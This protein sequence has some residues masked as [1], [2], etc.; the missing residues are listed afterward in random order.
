MNVIR[1]TAAHMLVMLP[2]VLA[3]NAAAQRAV[4]EGARIR[5]RL[6]G[7]EPIV[8]RLISVGGDSLLLSPARTNDFRTYP[9]SEIQ[10][11]KLSHAGI[12]GAAWKGMT[13]GSLG[14][15]AFLG[16]M[17]HEEALG[18]TLFGAFLGSG[19]GLVFGHAAS[20]ESGRLPPCRRSGRN[21]CR[22][23]RLVLRCAHNCSSTR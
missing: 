20:R 11:V 15:A 5:I 8:G 9:L 4:V 12:E 13:A 6:P 14:F 21:D 7:Q 3:V 2:F 17:S 22:P 16:L 1:W 10:S 18:F 19:I 23:Q